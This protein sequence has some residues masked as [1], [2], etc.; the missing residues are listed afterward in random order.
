[1]ASGENSNNFS[2]MNCVEPDSSPL[3]VVK[4]ASCRV[5]GTGCMYGTPR[6][7]IGEDNPSISHAQEAAAAS[8]GA[9]QQRWARYVSADPAVC[10]DMGHHPG[11]PGV[12]Y[13]LFS[14]WHDSA[15][16]E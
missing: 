10:C 15:A 7:R 4:E 3:T 11:R 5:D 9:S 8:E 12:R 6:E 16:L 1:M 14:P 2:N 13:F